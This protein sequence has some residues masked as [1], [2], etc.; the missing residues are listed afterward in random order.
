MSKV[1]IFLAGVIALGSIS[2]Y[3]LEQKAVQKSTEQARPA[4]QE[5]RKVESLELT[6]SGS[7][8]SSETKNAMRITL[9]LKFRNHRRN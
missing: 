7:F 1:A 4:E 3:G 8:V 6:K 5:A 2:T 9:R